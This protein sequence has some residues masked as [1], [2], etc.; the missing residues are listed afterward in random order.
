MVSKNNLAL[1]RVEHCTVNHYPAIIKIAH[2]SG[3][4]E[5]ENLQSAI[6]RGC[7]KPFIVLLE[8]KCS[9]IAWV[10]LEQNLTARRNIS[11]LGNFVNFHFVVS[12]HSQVLS[13]V[14]DSQFIYVRL[15]EGDLGGGQTR[16]D[17]PKLN[18]VVIS[19]SDYN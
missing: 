11:A 9:D 10:T 19:C 6:F 18:S 2:V 12:S 16:S 13:I 8:P 14:S 1:I 3:S 4:F 7:K 15:G 5:V 17:I